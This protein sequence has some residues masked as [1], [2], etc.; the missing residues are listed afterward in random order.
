[1]KKSDESGRYHYIDYVKQSSYFPY[2]DLF[3]EK[4]ISYTGYS[5]TEIDL[6]LIP[7]DLLEEI[8]LENPN[9]IL[10]LYR[11]LA[12][13]LEYTEKRIQMTTIS[14]AKDRIIQMLGLWMLD[15]GTVKT[16]HVIIPYSLTIS[17]L[18]V[19]A[20][21]TRETASRVVNLLSEEGVINFSRK[22]IVYYQPDYF[23]QAFTR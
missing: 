18:A 3:G 16:D 9:Q 13:I 23:M 12:N 7:V 15:M 19:V 11:N 1:M 4:N 17:E 21:T 10:Y 6:M 20:G 14:S 22:E 8:T 2:G 5:V